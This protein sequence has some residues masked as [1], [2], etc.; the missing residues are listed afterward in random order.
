MLLEI[1]ETSDYSANERLVLTL[2]RKLGPMSKAELTRATGLSAQSASVIVRR[3]HEAGLLSQQK[4]TR[5][6]IGQP[7]KP[8]ALKEDGAFAIGVKI[9]RRTAEVVTANFGFEITNSNVLS[10]D[11]PAFE[12]LRASLVETIAQH[13]G[14]I[15]DDIDR[16]RLTLTGDFVLRRR[17]V[18]ARLVLGN[19]SARVDKTLLRN[20]ALGWTFLEEIKAGTTMKAIA[21]RE[22]RSQRRIAQLVDMALLAPD[23]IE[24]I[25]DGRQPATLS[26]DLLK[27]SPHKTMWSDQ[28]AWLQAI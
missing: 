20:V 23:I 5:G 27:R 15:P 22:N 19:S 6:K 3:L 11:Y 13:L 4:A 18:E 7:S 24:A 14:L 1:S 10:F 28:R 16:D 25:I 26:A 21:D 9:G 12:P 2:I 8:F 17:G